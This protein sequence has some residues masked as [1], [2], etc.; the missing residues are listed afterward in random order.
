MIKSI[1]LGAR[2]YQIESEGE[3]SVENLTLMVD[4]AVSFHETIQEINAD[5]KVTFLEKAK[6]LFFAPQIIQI[7]THYKD[8]IAEW[9]DLTAYEIQQ[10]INIF[11]AHFKL[12]NQDAESFLANVHHLT[13]AIAGFYKLLNK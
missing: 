4:L 8:V 5:N 13:M 9:E 2:S 10:L 11:A 1:K 6:L 3:R 12:N 7:A